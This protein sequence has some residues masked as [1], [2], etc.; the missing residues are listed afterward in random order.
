MSK[1]KSTFFCQN[2]GHESAK[3]VGKCPNCNEWN[4]FVEEVVVKGTDKKQD[5]WKDFGDKGRSE[6]HT[7]ELQSQ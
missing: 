5:E 6:E 4:T 2:C 7:S 3:W 1:T